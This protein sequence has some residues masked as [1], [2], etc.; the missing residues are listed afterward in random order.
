[1]S[2]A[3]LSYPIN[4]AAKTIKL[5]GMLRGEYIALERNTM[6]GL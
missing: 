6:S 5:K 1:M 2:Q 3:S 4:L